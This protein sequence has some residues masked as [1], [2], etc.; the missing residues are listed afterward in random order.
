MKIIL[1]LEQLTKGYQRENSR[2]L[3]RINRQL[4]EG[5]NGTREDIIQ[6]R[7]RAEIEDIPGSP[8]LLDKKK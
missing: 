8:S 1:L 5:N 6:S 3:T 7:V 2:R 4:H